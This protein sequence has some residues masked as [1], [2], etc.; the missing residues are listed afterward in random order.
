MQSGCSDFVWLWARPSRHLGSQGLLKVC[1]ICLADGLEQWFSTRDDFLSPKGHL[2]MTA[3][4]FGCHYKRQGR[5]KALLLGSRGQ[6]PG[7]LLNSCSTQDSPASGRD[8][9][10]MS[11]VPR[12]GKPGSER[13]SGTYFFLS[14]PEDMFEFIYLLIYLLI[15]FRE[16]ETSIG[17]WL[18][19]EPTTLLVPGTTLQLAEPPG[20]GT[21]A[22]ICDLY[23]LDDQV[24]PWA[25]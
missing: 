11:A 9:P 5:D 4:I 21:G 3:D 17:P 18:G 7:V 25:Y 23:S 12:C 6:R 2:A 22:Y 1:S 14:S 8:L 15:Y 16:R 19:I 13:D 20:Q 10:P 24:T